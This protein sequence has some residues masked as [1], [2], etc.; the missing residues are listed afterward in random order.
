[1]PTPCSYIGL[2][3]PTTTYKVRILYN[4]YVVMAYTSGS[5]SHA[6]RCAKKD[7]AAGGKGYSYTIL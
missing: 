3:S 4:G 2:E 6:L 5:Y 7:V 1:M